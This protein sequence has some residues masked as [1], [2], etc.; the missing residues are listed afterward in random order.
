MGDAACAASQQA[1]STWA[2]E[3]AVSLF[4]KCQQT[5]GT[6]AALTNARIRIRL[7]SPKAVRDRAFLGNC[8]G[9]KSAANA[10]SSIG[11]GAGA[12]AA[13]AQSSCAGK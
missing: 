13:Y 2:I 6:P 8:P 12:Q 3:T 5:G 4:N 7:S 9:A 1:A 10:A 11:E